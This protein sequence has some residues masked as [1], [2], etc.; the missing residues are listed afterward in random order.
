MEL[1]VVISIIAILAAL[2]I[3]AVTS[4]I[5]RGQLTQ[6]LNNARQIHLS[7]QQMALDRTTTGDP[8]IGWPGDIDTTGDDA[9]ELG[10][11]ADFA[12]LLID[13][14]YLGEG[15]LRIFTAAGVTA[16]LNLEALTSANIAFAIGEVREVNSSDTIFIVTA[17]YQTP[18]ELD[19]NQEPFGDKGWV[20]FR[21]GGDGGY[22]RQRQAEIDA[23][24]DR[25]RQQIG[26]LPDGWLTGINDT[27]P[28]TA[29]DDD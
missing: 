22:Y 14:G 15:D 16:A 6:A 13:E 5:T 7:T 24:T 11:A 10:D 3:P 29:T 26:R 1:L 20:V 19:E 2:A 9:P 28:P 12:R 21:K 17:N 27:A 25:F 18:G 23:G 4:A 8:I